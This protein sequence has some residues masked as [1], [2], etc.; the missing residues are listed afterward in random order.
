MLKSRLGGRRLRFEDDERRRL[1]E[2][3]HRL[4]RRLLGQVATLVTPD[5]ILRGH[6][7]LVARKWTYRVG[8]GRP[9]GLQ[10]HL[11]ALVIRMATENPTWATR[12]FRAR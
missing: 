7:E 12:G 3:G 4:G 11:R 8:H 5:T 6:R 2:L 9:A 10:A 1:G